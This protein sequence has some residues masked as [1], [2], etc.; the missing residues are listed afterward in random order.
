MKRMMAAKSAAVLGVAA[1]TLAACGG[2]ESAS[3]ATAPAS[4]AASAAATAAAGECTTTTLTL[5]R[6]MPETGSLAFLGEPMITGI[7]MAVAEVN[8]A[9]GVNGAD[10]TLVPGDEGDSTTDTA[11]QTVDSQLSQGVTA[12]VGAAGSGMT[13]TVID[14]VTSNGVMMISPSNTTPALTEYDDAGLYF[15]T[16]P[17]DALQGAVISANAIDAGFTKV[18]AIARQDSY[19]EG[20]LNAFVNDFTTSG[21]TVTSEIL[22]DPAA[23]SFEAEVAEIKAGNPE[24]VVVISFDEGTKLLQEMIKQ[25]VGPQDVQ[26][27]L[28]D[29]NTSTTAYESFP[30]GTMKGTIG[31]LPTGSAD[32]TAFNERMLEF[33]PKLTD[34]IYGAQAFDATIIAA[35]AAQ[36]AGCADGAAI[37]AKVIDVTGN[38]GEKCTDFTTC[39]AL[40]AE[41]K[42][43]DYDGVTSN[44]EMNQYG[45]PAEGTISV[46][47]YKTNTEFDE[48]DLITAE[49]PLPQ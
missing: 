13:L 46:K 16:A 20:L 37:A 32:V 5:G 30:E 36:A 7:E 40:L 21:G 8:E 42:D 41:G 26:V 14:K 43:I 38:G 24:A 25:G 29:G 18:A 28:V 33:N 15:R 44:L 45:D 3:E 17:S 6:L 11:S 49:V 34:Y 19:G 31:T 4:E 2:S 22:Y 48:I 39:S 9:G 1:L 47:K 23:A 12:I 27:Y 10:V 35:L